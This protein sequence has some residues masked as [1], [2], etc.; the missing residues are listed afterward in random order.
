MTKTTWNMLRTS[1]ELCGF[2][3]SRGG[4]FSASELGLSVARE[5]FFSA[6]SDRSSPSV[7]SA[8]FSSRTSLT[9]SEALRDAANGSCSVVEVILCAGPI[10]DS[11]FSFRF[12]FLLHAP[13]SSEKTGH[14]KN[15]KPAI[16]ISNRFLC[17]KSEG[18]RKCS[19]PGGSPRKSSLLAILL[20]QV[21][22]SVFSG[23]TDPDSSMSA[24]SPLS[25]S[26]ASPVR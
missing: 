26:P 25:G 19:N 4:N 23:D 12:L 21:L 15:T 10:M 20:P 6:M 9:C 11:D 14:P 13:L 3:I 7:P 22:P 16:L 2:F 24:S 5:S 8:V 17:A 1:V 18:H